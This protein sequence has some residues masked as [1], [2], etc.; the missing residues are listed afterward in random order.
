MPVEKVVRAVVHALTARHP[1]TRYP[2]GA[3]T[4]V[5]TALS[6]FVSD[7]VRDWFLRRQFGLS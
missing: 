1:R 6:R 7:R 4:R 5:A 2:V 3:E